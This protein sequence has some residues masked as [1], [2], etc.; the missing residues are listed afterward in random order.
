[1]RAI[2]RIVVAAVAIGLLLG[3][4]V[5]VLLFA[6]SD[7][8]DPFVGSVQEHWSLIWRRGRS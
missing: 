8:L 7:W 1:M 4:G 2:V 6:F 5:G 3:G